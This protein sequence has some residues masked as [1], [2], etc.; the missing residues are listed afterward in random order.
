[1]FRS[2]RRGSATSSRGGTPQTRTTLNRTRTE[3]FQTNGEFW[4]S[5]R[6]AEQYTV[7]ILTDRSSSCREPFVQENLLL[8]TK[9]FQAFLNR[10]LKTDLVNAKNALMVF[11]VTKVFAQPNLAEIIQKGESTWVWS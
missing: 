4:R 3:P 9:L 5:T 7:L 8:Y 2:W 6:S 10:A 1:M 11:R